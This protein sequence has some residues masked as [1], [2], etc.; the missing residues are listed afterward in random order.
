VLRVW[1]V[2]LCS[3]VRLFMPER[4]RTPLGGATTE[5][6]GRQCACRAVSKSPT[7]GH[8]GQTA[9]GVPVKRFTNA[10]AEGVAGRSDR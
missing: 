7:A 9:C 6:D 1:C 10:R 5:G 4:V 3:C 2:R 8:E